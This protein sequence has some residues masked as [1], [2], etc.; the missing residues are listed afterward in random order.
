V[1][2]AILRIK[3]FKPSVLAAIWTRA[4]ATSSAACVAKFEQNLPSRFREIDP[5][6]FEKWQKRKI[7][8]NTPRF[9]HSIAYGGAPS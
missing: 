1:L 5:L 9:T 8:V 7:L 3:K 4:E 6:L 2:S